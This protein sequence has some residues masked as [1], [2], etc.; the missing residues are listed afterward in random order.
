MSVTMMSRLM[1]N[2]HTVADS[3]LYASHR[4]TLQL[5]AQSTLSEF[6]AASVIT[7]DISYNELTV[8]V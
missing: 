5:E 4:T 1:F 2:L 7:S 6:R 8:G 3:G